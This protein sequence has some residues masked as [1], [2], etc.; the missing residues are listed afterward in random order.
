MRYPANQQNDQRQDCDE[1]PGY[2]RM[3]CVAKDHT[4]VPRSHRGSVTRRPPKDPEAVP[5]GVPPAALSQP[6]R[7]GSSTR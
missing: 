7:R 4:Q 3:P 5:V 6:S 2:A 1:E